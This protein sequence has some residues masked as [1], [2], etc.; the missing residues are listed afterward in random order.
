M[1]SDR[2]PPLAE[3]LA[4]AIEWWRTAGVDHSF[5]DQAEPWLAEPVEE[6]APEVATEVRQEPAKAED[7]PPLGGPRAAW[8]ADLAAFRDW[9]LSEPSLSE[10]GTYP[11]V[12]P[13]GEAGADILLLVDQPEGSDRDTL[14]SGPEG[15]LLD[16]MLQAMGIAPERAYFASVLPRHTPLAD[17]DGIERSGLREVIEHHIGLAA[18][19]RII[20][21]GRL[22]SAIISHGTAQG[23][24]AKP[25]FNQEVPRVPVMEARSLDA[26]RRR[27]GARA[28]FW[29]SWLEF[30][31]GV[32]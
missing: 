24:A 20:A 13:R 22:A 25:V 32:A 19:A 18:P 26:L 17:L 7:A 10:E 16:A 31:D 15:K 4:A 23:A 28:G 8:P 30:S 12:S 11:R 5:G 29:R 6:A 1:T 3:E 2:Q 27:P 9:W 21:F 14:L